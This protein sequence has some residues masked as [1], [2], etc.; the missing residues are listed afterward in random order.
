VR[1]GLLAR[2]FVYDPRCYPDFSWNWLGRFFFYVGL[3]FNTAFTA[4]FYAARTDRSGR[5][6]RQYRRHFRTAQRR[7]GD[8]RRHR[9]RIRLR[10][11]GPRKPFVLAA[12][13]LFALGA[14]VMALSGS[15]P[16]L[17]AGSFV[18]SLGLGLFSAVDQALLLDVMPER[19]TEPGR[20]VAINQFATSIP[21]GLAPYG[22]LREGAGFYFRTCLGHAPTTSSTGRPAVTRR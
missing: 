11:R 21:Q 14:L 12:G 6:R 2:K 17:L 22:N 18:A 19:E 7:G 13:I 4:N 8:D 1:V 3:T 9:Q 16:L 10:P 5:R 20:F 15:L